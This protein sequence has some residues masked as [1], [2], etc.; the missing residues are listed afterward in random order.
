MAGCVSQILPSMASLMAVTEAPV[1]T[2]MMSSWSSTFT[3]VFKGFVAGSWR[4]YKMYSCSAVTVSS[5]VRCTGCL[6]R[7][8]ENFGL[9]CTCLLDMTLFPTCMARCIMKVALRGVM[10]PSTPVA[11]LCAL[12]C[13]GVTGGWTNL[14]T[15]ALLCAPACWRSLASHSASSMAWATFSALSKVRPPS[16][17]RH[18]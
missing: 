9:A 17:R 3:L 18:C 1:S 6:Y 15:P 4:G 16:A 11:T 14:W 10:T 2:S 5:S 7:G 12:S 13:Q 8:T